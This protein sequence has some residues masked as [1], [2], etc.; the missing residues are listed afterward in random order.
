MENTDFIDRIDSMKRLS[1][2][3]RLMCDCDHLFEELERYKSCVPKS[4][5]R[6]SRRQIDKD[7]KEGIK[8][9]NKKIPVFIELPSLKKEGNGSYSK[10]FDK[11][12]I[13]T[14]SDISAENEITYENVGL[15]ESGDD[16]S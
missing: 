13:K 1:V 4:F 10:K 2:K 7:Y 8:Q 5:Y 14:A 11:K 9:I 6:R 12:K 16:I 15:L 3:G